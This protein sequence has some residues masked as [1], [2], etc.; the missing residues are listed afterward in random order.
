M[1]CRR[2]LTLPPLPPGPLLSSPCLNSCMTRPVVFLWRGDVLGMAKSFGSGL[3]AC[4]KPSPET[5]F[6]ERGQFL[7]CARSTTSSSERGGGRPK[8]QAIPR[9]PM[10]KIAKSAVTASMTSSRLT[11]S[12][13]RFQTPPKLFWCAL[14]NRNRFAHGQNDR[15]PALAA[16]L[17]DRR[18]AGIVTL[19]RPVSAMAAPFRENSTARRS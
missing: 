3:G 9:H 14:Q 17:V 18:V 7:V 5:T 6:H 12:N 15:L 4:G 19:L 13:P 2:L 10:A 16:D 8:P 11:M 1:A